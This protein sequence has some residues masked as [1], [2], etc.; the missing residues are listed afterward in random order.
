MLSPK[1]AKKLA[2]LLRDNARG[3]IG[4]K[5]LCGSLG[6]L[7][8]ECTEKELF[9][10]IPTPFKAQVKQAILDAQCLEAE[11][12]P[13]A[14][15]RTSRLFLRSDLQLARFLLKPHK[16]MRAMATVVAKPSF[17]YPW[18]FRLCRCQ[19]SY[20][21][22]GIVTLLNGT[23]K[24][25]QNSRAKA[26]VQTR[27]VPIEDCLGNDI[28]EIWENMLLRVKQLEFARRVL[29]GVRY[30]F[31]FGRRGGFISTPD[32]KTAPGKLV[33]ISHALYEYVEGRNLSDVA[34]KAQVK[35]LL[36]WLRTPS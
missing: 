27:C 31:V 20:Q 22:A 9:K 23:E 21:Y 32:R 36:S 24:P 7:A 6:D 29:D 30:H 14:E 2:R 28:C 5:E 17:H 25:R 26:L 18:A 1:S 19:K 16:S 8:M 4:D 33:A 11:P 10:R 13:F 3:L 12:S 34:L 15:S 35:D